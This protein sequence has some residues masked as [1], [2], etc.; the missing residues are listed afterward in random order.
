MDPG[1][2]GINRGMD[3]NREYPDFSKCMVVDCYKENF[4]LK[5]LY[6]ECD[7]MDRKLK[8]YLDTV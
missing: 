6:R 3:S 4:V 2:V 5:W 8:V 1:G 7:A